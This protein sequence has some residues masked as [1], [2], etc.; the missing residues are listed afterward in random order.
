MALN[1]ELFSKLDRLWG[2]FAATGRI[3]PVKSLTSAL[4]WRED[5]EAF[6]QM[7]KEGR[8]APELTDSLVRALTYMAAG[9]SL[10]SFKRSDGLAADYIEAIAASAETP[11][12]IKKQL[13]GLDSEPAFK[14]DSG[15]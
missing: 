3:E 7:Q 8:K 12:S 6:V 14:R 15:K 10:N 11:A 2:N 4:A 13:A 1:R 9:W 5:Y